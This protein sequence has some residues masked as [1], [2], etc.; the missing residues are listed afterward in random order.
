[1]VALS[2]FRMQK[3]ICL[4]EQLL[5]NL[6]I[7]HSTSKKTLGIISSSY[8][9]KKDLLDGDRFIHRKKGTFAS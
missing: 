2:E 4:S 5:G 1:M 6:P 3:D 7:Y 9:N 8:T